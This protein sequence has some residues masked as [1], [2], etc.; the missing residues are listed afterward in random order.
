MKEVEVVTDIP[1]CGCPTLKAGTKLEVIKNN[2][3]FVYVDYMGCELKLSV[4]DIKIVKR[5]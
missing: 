4:K 1:I 3:R 2:T 5:K